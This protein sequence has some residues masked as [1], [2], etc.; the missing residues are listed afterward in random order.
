M[1]DSYVQR[2]EATGKYY[3]HYGSG[4]GPFLTVEI[5]RPYQPKTGRACSCKRGQQ[6]DNCPQCE[7]T[8]QCIDFKAIR[9]R[10]GR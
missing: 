2:C 8:G 3:R 7:G 6:R 9:E 4:N 1:K 5:K 10:S